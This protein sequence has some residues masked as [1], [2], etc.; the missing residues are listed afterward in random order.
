MS[1]GRRQPQQC[2]HTQ[3]QYL[4]VRGAAARRMVKRIHERSTPQ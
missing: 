2:A 1:L 4:D 3:Q